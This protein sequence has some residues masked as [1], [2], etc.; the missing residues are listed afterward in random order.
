M[1]VCD[2]P[3]MLWDK[4]EKNYDFFFFKMKDQGFD[5]PTVLSSFQRI[6]ESL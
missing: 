2:I 1:S 5:Y 4:S 6:S 3:G